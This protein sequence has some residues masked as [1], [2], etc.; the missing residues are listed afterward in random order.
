MNKVQKIDYVKEVSNGLEQ[1]SVFEIFERLT[2]E[3]IVH[4]PENPIDFLIDRL[5]TPNGKQRREEDTSYSKNAKNR[6]IAK[7]RILVIFR[8]Q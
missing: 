8:D 7:N 5:K 1:K 2:R 6:K 4:Q 3:L